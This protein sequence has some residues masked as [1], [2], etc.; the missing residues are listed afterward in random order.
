MA[1][2]TFRNVSELAEF[3]AVLVTK[4]IAFKVLYSGDDYVV[5]MTGY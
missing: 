2:A 1:T 4:G 5:E 3:C